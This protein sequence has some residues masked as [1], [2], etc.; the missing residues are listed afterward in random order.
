M[1]ASK[2]DIRNLLKSLLQLGECS[3][4]CWGVLH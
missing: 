1:D 3:Y 2:R 4:L